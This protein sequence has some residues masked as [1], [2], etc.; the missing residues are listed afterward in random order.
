M[1]H[2]LLFITLGLFVLSHSLIANDSVVAMEVGLSGCTDP[3]ACNFDPAADI[4]DGS[5]Q[6]DFNA[7]IF[8]IWTVAYEAT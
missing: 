8:N 4:D 7:A 1:K 3:A 5:C 6:Y 2:L